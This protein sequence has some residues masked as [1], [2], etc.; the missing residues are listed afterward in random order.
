MRITVM[1]IKSVMLQ[2]VNILRT[3]LQ[4]GVPQ[5]YFACNLC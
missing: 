1:E 5:N 2:N 4:R 3:H